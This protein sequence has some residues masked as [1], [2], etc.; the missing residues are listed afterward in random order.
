[1]PSLDAHVHCG[2][3]ESHSVVQPVLA[4]RLRD[5][6]LC[7]LERDQPALIAPPAS[8]TQRSWRPVPTPQCAIGWKLIDA[9]PAA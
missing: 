9:A 1:V 2:Q 7:N 3:A 4:Y 6:K 5:E 8:G